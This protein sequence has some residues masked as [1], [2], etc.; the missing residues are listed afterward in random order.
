MVLG[1]IQ[2]FNLVSILLLILPGLAGTKLYLREV[3]RQD[4]FGRIDTVVISIAGSLGGLLIMYLW[5]WVFLSFENC[6]SGGPFPAS[7]PVWT[8][9]KSRVDTLSEQIFHY[10]T[11]VGIVTG[12]GYTL[13]SEGLLIE[14]LPD[15]PNKPWRTLLEGVQGGEDDNHLRVET[16]SGDQITG[17]LVEWSVES[18]SLVLQNGRRHRSGG[19]SREL[20][21]S[22]IYLEK[23]EIARLS[24]VTPQSGD[25]PGADGEGAEPDEQTNDLV[26]SAREG[27]SSDE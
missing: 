5:Y 7:A 23:N 1:G 12:T 20:P 8:D 17:E 4:R 13:G 27:D 25:G 3:S 14:Q 22:R 9:L 11:L 19:R 15:P 2:A 26:E 10:V 18:Q 24:V 6:V 21:G 16:S